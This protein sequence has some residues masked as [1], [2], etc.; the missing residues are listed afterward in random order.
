MEGGEGTVAE[1]AALQGG[2]GGGREVEG[3][4]TGVFVRV[5][6]LG[7]IIH[8]DSIAT[9]VPEVVVFL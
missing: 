4:I 8:F 3:V 6:F 2:G 1:G 9:D 7:R 5:S